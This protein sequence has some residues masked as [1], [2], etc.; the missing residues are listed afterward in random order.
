MIE[1]TLLLSPHRLR[2]QVCDIHTYERRIDI[3]GLA[4]LH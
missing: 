2:W 1:Q 3:N 4:A